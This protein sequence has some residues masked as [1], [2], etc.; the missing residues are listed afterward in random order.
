MLIGY[1][2]LYLILGVLFCS[3]YDYEVYMIP[4]Q[5]KYLWSSSHMQSCHRPPC[6]VIG[7]YIICIRV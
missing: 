2:Y 5:R 1:V 7:F 6:G 3:Y 4:G